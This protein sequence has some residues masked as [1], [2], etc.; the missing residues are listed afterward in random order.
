MSLSTKITDLMGYFYHKN[1]KKSQNLI[2]YNHDKIRKIIGT[3]EKSSEHNFL[4]LTPCN[5]VLI[6]LDLK[7]TPSEFLDLMMHYPHAN[8]RHN[9]Q[10]DFGKN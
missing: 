8:N 7:K 6:I 1:A 9:P 5:P 3:A 2:I 4:T 10:S